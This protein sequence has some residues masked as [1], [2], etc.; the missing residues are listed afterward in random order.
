[1][2]LSIISMYSDSIITLLLLL[3][4]PIVTIIFGKL[5]NEEHKNLSRYLIA[6][7]AVQALLWIF[8]AYRIISGMIAFSSIVAQ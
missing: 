2:D 8:Q 3:P 1:M 6:L 5:L 7:G 4:V